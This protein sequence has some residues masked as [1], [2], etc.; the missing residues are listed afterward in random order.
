MAFS[1]VCTALSTPA[2]QPCG[3]ASNTLR[4]GASSVV[5]SGSSFRGCG[6]AGVG[7]GRP[8]PLLP[9]EFQNEAAGRR[10]RYGLRSHADVRTALGLRFGARRDKSDAAPRPLRRAGVEP[11]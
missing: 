11:I 9:T 1:T 2:H 5:M 6:M 8:S 7:T 3:E 4:V 10:C